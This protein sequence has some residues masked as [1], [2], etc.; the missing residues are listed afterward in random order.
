LEV[1][2]VADFGEDDVRF[3]MSFS[4]Q[5]IFADPLADPVGTE[6]WRE[7]MVY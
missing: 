7:R 5:E 6:R 4:P 3:S 1:G 2:V